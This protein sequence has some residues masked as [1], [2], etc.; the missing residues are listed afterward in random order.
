MAT[1]SAW[2]AGAATLLAAIG[3]Y[4]VMAY[5]V[6][7]RAREIG[8]R[9]ALG[10]DRGTLLGLVLRE[11]GSMTAVG[12]GVAIPVA[13]GLTRL[14]RSQLYEVAPWDP[15]SVAGAAAIVAVVALAAGYAPAAR[16]TRMSAAAALR[17]E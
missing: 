5:V 17:E 9:A 13:L 4:G 3:L 2:F 7:R 10:A 12:V 16:A 8:I 1:L 15:V 14:V 11:A 6:S